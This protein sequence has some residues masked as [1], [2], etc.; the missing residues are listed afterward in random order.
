MEELLLLE[1]G[2]DGPEEEETLLRR[3]E[4]LV[5]VGRRRAAANR[6]KEK[7]LRGEDLWESGRSL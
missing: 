2:V 5:L 6:L 7:R 3:G 4:G 1:D